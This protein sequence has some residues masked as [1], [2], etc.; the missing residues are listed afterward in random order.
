MEYRYNGE[1]NFSG[2][3]NS[4]ACFA[5]GKRVRIDHDGDGTSDVLLRMNGLSEAGQLTAA[6]FLW[7]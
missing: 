6:D 7:L 1:N 5:G 4:E 2:G 3:G